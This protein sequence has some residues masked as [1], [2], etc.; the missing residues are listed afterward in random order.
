MPEPGRTG[1]CSGPSKAVSSRQNPNSS[2]GDGSGSSSSGGDMPG[3]AEA[4]ARLAGGIAI[5]EQH[6][7]SF[8]RQRACHRLSR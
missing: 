2:P 5:D 7:A 1:M 3:I 4:R 8:E 6:P